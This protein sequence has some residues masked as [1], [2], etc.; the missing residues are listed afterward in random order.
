V[1][2]VLSKPLQAGSGA[3]PA[4]YSTGIG[5]GGERVLSSNIKQPEPEADRLSPPS[6]EVKNA[7]RYL[8]SYYARENF[9]IGP[10]HGSGG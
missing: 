10:C 8:F 5:G 6:S 4:T 7:W 2:F 9:T 3:Y 1:D